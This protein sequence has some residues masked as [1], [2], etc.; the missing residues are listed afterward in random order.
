MLIGG[1][2]NCSSTIS[3]GL[4][5]KTTTTQKLSAQDV[6]RWRQAWDEYVPRQLVVLVAE[7]I[8]VNYEQATAAPL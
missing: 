8:Q 7:A 5:K 1:P 6:V 3:S 4:K 2:G